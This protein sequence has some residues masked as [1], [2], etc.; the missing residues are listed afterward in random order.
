MSK[1]TSVTMHVYDKSF[2]HIYRASDPLN[3]L[4]YSYYILKENK[5]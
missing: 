1:M 3:S 4:P 5:K 2:G